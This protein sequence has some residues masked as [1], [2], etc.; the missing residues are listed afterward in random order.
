M[1][2]NQAYMKADIPHRTLMPDR[3]MF[4]VIQHPS[5][6]MLPDLFSNLISI[7]NS[8]K[9]NQPRELCVSYSQPE[10]RNRNPG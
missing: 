6:E 7:K 8:K 1:C 4:L 2:D 3:T 9:R 10:M 5:F